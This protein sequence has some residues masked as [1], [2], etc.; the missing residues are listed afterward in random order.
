M[1][2]TLVFGFVMAQAPA[3]PS[4]SKL[5]SAML[6]KY[7]AA[8]TIV[9]TIKLTQTA[10]KESGSILTTFQFE[11]PAKLTIRQVQEKSPPRVWLV[12]SDGKHFSYPAPDADIYPNSRLVENIAKDTGAMGLAEIYHASAMGLGDRSAPLDIAIGSKEDLKFI[13]GQWATLALGGKTK[14]GEI[15][16]QKIKGTWREVAGG[17]PMGRY[18]LWL[19]AENNMKRYVVEQSVKLDPAQPAIRIVS[20]WDINLKIDGTPDQDL[21][22]VVL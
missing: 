15:E 17:A 22:K 18:E 1:I 20:V 5:V 13:A 12:T 21:F 6:A 14:L 2:A 3:E 9:G 10:G 7:A 8:K 4:P 11:K 19:D 16:C